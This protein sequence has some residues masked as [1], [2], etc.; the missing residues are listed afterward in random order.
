MPLAQ[1]QQAS[2]STSTSMYKNTIV[3]LK[4]KKQDWQRLHSAQF[5]KDK[6]N[7][8]LVVVSETLGILVSTLKREVADAKDEA[9]ASE[10][11]D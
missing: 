6:V 3:D 1:P 11:V 10:A 5:K 8:Y 4:W 9:P 7:D 2:N